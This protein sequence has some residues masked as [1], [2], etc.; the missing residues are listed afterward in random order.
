MSRKNRLI[1]TGGTVLFGVAILD[2]IGRRP[3]ERDWHGKVLGFPYDFRLPTRERLR[4]R[5]WNPQVERIIVPTV[6]G[7][8]WTVNLYQ[9]RRRALLLIA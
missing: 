6:V 9:L 5:V 2:Q 1:A 7:I 3:E 8:G 4:E